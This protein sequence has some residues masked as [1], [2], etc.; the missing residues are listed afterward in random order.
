MAK[1]EEAVKVNR[2]PK[3][4][5]LLNAKFRQKY[6]N[7]KAIEDRV[8]GNIGNTLWMIEQIPKMDNQDRINRWI[9]WIQAKAHSN[10]L[11]TLD[12]I[13]NISRVDISNFNQGTA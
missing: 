11:V 9:G 3:T 6:P 7:T 4:L 2:Y 10:H 1:D 13:L 12:D 5:A 8:T